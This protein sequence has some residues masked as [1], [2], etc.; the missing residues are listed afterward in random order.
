MSGAALFLALS[1][2]AQAVGDTGQA[3]SEVARN[4]LQTAVPAGGHRALATNPWQ[5]VLRATTPTQIILV[6]LA[7]FSVV[8][9]VLI[10]W[11][12]SE[13]RRVGRQGDGFVMG[14]ERAGGLE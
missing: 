5:M 8:S 6:V 10:F 1:R 13:F 9:W 14:M 7:V 11:K 4:A 12:W 3:A 2:L